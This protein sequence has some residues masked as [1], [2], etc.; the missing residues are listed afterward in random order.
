MPLSHSAIFYDKALRC[1]GMMSSES[2]LH[3]NLGFFFFLFFLS[4]SPYTCVSG[5]NETKDTLCILFAF[6]TVKPTIERGTRNAVR[7]ESE[8]LGKTKL[9]FARISFGGILMK[10]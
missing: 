4:L 7:G 6:L 1:T 9:A 5:K 3:M 10:V 8:R 2:P